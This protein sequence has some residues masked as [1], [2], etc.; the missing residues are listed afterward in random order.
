[1]KLTPLPRF[2]PL[3]RTVALSDAVFAVVMT[4]LVLGIEVPESGELTGP[5]VGEKLGHQLLVYFVSFWIVAMFWAQHSLVFGRLKRMDRGMLVL[6]LM[7]LLPVTLLPFVT[8]LM[9]TRQ[10]DWIAVLV[11]AVTNLFAVF[12][13]LRLWK[14]VSEDPEISGGPQMA[15]LAARIKLGTWFYIAALFIGVLVALVNVRLGILCFVL[16]PI[17]HFY[18]YFRTADLGTS[19]DDA[20]VD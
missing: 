7:F 9:G 12:V 15:S 13:F 20:P 16:P 1:M 17:A 4:L 3:D 19:A 14:R 5:A 10:D 2:F 8:Q 6:N 18:N 11:F